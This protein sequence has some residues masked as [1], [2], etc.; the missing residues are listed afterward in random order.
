MKTSRLSIAVIAALLILPALAAEHE[1]PDPVL[2][3]GIENPN[4]TQSDIQDTI[5]KS[6]WT[7]TVRPPVSYTNELKKQQ[8]EEW[9]YADKTMFN[10]EEDHV[11]PLEVGGHPSDPKNL[12]PEPYEG[13]WNAIVKDR[14]ENFVKHE[15]CAGRMA[16]QDGQNIF[17]TNW[18][19]GFK[20]YC[21][22]TSDSKCNNGD[23]R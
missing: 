20:K 6:G 11:I 13:E 23:N 9:G 1:S 16:L 3:R 4:V 10:Y 5:C 7:K 2:A 21:G 18:I 15:V 14:L 19:E 8:L 12:W 17:K 22:P